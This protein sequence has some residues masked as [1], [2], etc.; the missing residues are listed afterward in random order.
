MSSVP[1]SQDGG[2]KKVPF[3][4]ISR[5]RKQPTPLGTTVFVGLRSLDPFLQYGILAKGVGSG[6]LTRIGLTQLPAGLGTNTGTFIDRLGLSP[7]RLI[8]LSLATGSSIKQ[9][10]WLLGTSQEEFPPGAAIPVAAYNTVFNSVNNLLFTTTLASAS[11]ASDSAFP[12]WPLIVGVT[13]YAIGMGLEIV[14][15]NQRAN[16]KKDPK[17]TGKPFTGGLWSV[18][19]HINYTGYSLWRAGF[20]CAAAGFPAGLVVLGFCLFDFNIRAIPVLDNYCS[21]RYGADWVAYKEKT[22]YKLLPGVY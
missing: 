1:K 4:L 11:L 22:P 16:F 12:Q 15:E 7:Y 19:R 10:Y 20:T 5:G 9:I 13:A 8:L 18:A 3:D 14:S 21:G 17:N 2:E 6:L